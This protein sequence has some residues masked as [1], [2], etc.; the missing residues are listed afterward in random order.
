VPETP[1]ENSRVALYATLHDRSGRAV[2][3]ANVEATLTH[4]NGKTSTS[5]KLRQEK[6]GWGLYKGSFTPEEGG[7]YELQIRCRETGSD[8]KIKLD[9]AGKVREKIGQPL[10]RNSLLEIARITKG[11]VFKTE[12]LNKLVKTIKA[13]PK[14]IELEKRFL[15]WCQWWWAAIIIALLTTYWTIRKINGLI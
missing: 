12:E 13:L 7:I 14:Q 9:V 2:D 8:V 3:N 1:R 4:E 5:F 6:E 11:S 15:L 10:R